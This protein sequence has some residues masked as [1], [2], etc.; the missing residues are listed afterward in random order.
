M[1]SAHFFP[2]KLTKTAS[3]LQSCKN[4]AVVIG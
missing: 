1:T 3:S 4:L 2:T